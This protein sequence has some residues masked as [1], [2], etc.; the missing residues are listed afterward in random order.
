MFAIRASGHTP[1]IWRTTWADSASPARTAVP[2]VVAV[3]AAGP[4]W[5]STG[6]RAEG[7]ALTR[8]TGPAA[9]SPSASTSRT[10]STR[11]PTVNGQ[12]SSNTDTSKFSDVEATT[13]DS[14]AGPRS[15]A[16]QAARPATLRCATSTPLGRPVDPEV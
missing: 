1:R 6:D 2:G 12:N 15:A 16:A 11:P 3:P 13:W 9:R 10:T 8:L 7:T 14:P 4:L 5:A